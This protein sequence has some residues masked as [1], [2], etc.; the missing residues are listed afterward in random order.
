MIVFNA[1]NPNVFVTIL[2]GTP[3]Y[4]LL[5]IFNEAIATFLLSTAWA[6]SAICSNY[7]LSFSISINRIVLNIIAIAI[8]MKINLLRSKSVFGMRLS[9]N[10][11]L[12]SLTIL[13]KEFAEDDEED[14]ELML[15]LPSCFSSEEGCDPN[16]DPRALPYFE[17]VK[18]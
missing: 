4:V 1:V 3:I 8:I 7:W 17:P 16:M 13:L 15:M 9:D 11:F 14:I 6:T 18:S 12:K 2:L 10:V 5:F